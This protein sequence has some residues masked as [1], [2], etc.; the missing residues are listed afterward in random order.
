MKQEQNEQIFEIMRRKA[1]DERT[2]A[3][4]KFELELELMRRDLDARIAASAAAASAAA[5]SAATTV[6]TQAPKRTGMEDDILGEVPP[7]IKN[8]S[9]CFA[10]LP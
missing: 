1:E 3:T 9:L 7:E 6:A 5:T 4:R 2:A 8:V 10:G